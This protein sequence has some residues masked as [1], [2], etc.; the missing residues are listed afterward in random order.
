MTDSL[1]N[2]NIPEYQ[3]SKVRTFSPSVCVLEAPPNEAQIGMCLC[4]HRRLFVHL[5]LCFHFFLQCNNTKGL[6]L[7]KAL[8][9][10]TDVSA[11]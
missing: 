6:K 5:F 4:P 11:G 10:L 3:H 7:H 9:W 2:M 8:S 1:L